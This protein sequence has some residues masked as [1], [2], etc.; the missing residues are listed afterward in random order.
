MMTKLHK[1]NHGFYW[2]FLTFMRWLEMNPKDVTGPQSRESLLFFATLSNYQP[3]C[4]T[5]WGYAA[6]F[7][8]AGLRIWWDG[9][10]VRACRVVGKS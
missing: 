5:P 8:K 2:V 4:F 7:S 3:F 1:I 10:S 6:E 9:I